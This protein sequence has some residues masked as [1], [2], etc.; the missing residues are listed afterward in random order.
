MHTKKDNPQVIILSFIII[1]GF[2]DTT[3]PCLAVVYNRIE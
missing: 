2:F 1:Q 3:S